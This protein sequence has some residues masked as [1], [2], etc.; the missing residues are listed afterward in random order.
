MSFQNYL[1]SCKLVTGFELVSE[2]LLLLMF[3]ICP[4]DDDETK[5][6]L[7]CESGDL[8]AIKS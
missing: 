6:E 3:D 4:D 1:I 8:F 7:H 2:S 5:H